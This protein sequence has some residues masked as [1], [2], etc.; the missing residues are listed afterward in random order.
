M[1]VESFAENIRELES[2]ISRNQYTLQLK[3]CPADKPVQTNKYGVY[4][5]PEAIPYI[6][7]GDMLMLRW[8]GSFEIVFHYDLRRKPA[9]GKV[10]VKENFISR[11]ESNL[12]NCPNHPDFERIW[13]PLD[14]EYQPRC[15]VC[16]HPL[17]ILL[18]APYPNIR[19]R[20]LA[21]PNYEEE[22]C[23]GDRKRNGIPE[24]KAG[25]FTASTQPIK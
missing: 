22:K 2:N 10:E 11:M 12:W 3:R 1:R 16:S 20:L 6:E 8:Y 5:H 4:L 21:L 24:R 14:A 18:A 17:K 19:A 7:I 13:P 15:T 9:Y 25:E 23:A